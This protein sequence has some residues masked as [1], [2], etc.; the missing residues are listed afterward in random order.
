M[1]ND[2]YE[3]LVESVA[4]DRK[5]EPEKV[6]ALV[7]QG[8]FTAQAAKEAGLID[9]IAY[10]DELKEQI[11]KEQKGEKLSVVRK[12]GEKKMDA[13]FSGFTGMMKLINLMMGIEPSSGRTYGD[14]IAVVYALGPIM[15]GESEQG[16]LGGSSMGADTIV[17][18]LRTAD[19]DKKVRAIVLRVDSPGGSALASDQI[20]RQVVQIKK[21]VIASMGDTAASGGYY[22]SMGAQQIF[23][24]PATLTGSIGVVGG[25]M[26]LGGTLN[27]L[28]I[29]TQVVS[30]GQNSGIFSA[31]QPFSPAERKAIMLL[32]KDTY[33]Q[34]TTKAAQGRKMD[35]DKL[36]ELA[37]GK[38]YTGRQAQ[39]LGLVDTIGTLRDAIIAAKVAA[40]L[41]KDK[42]VNLMILPKPKSV[43]EQFFGGPE[44][45]SKV[46]TSQ[47]RKAAP[48]L[49]APLADIEQLQHLFAEPVNLVLPYRVHIR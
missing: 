18:A 29:N 3:Q 6:R 27:K 13:D 44:I 35:L 30:R 22:I 16:L 17:K 20:W 23:A 41:D 21:P 12:Y 45:E 11:K 48:Q 24:E 46:V 9:R 2:L 36:E 32:M 34:F 42:K 8:L 33:L 5:L 43:F 38:V 19:E 4:S 10:E 1:I 14:K 31:D 25:K 28:G 15:S 37:Q 47:L 26:A 39:K 40:G 49:V 7:D